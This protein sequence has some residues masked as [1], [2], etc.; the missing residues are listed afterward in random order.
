MKRRLARELAVA[1]LYELEMNEMV[2]VDKASDFVIEM[3]LEE[4]NALRIDEADLDPRDPYLS[5]LIKGVK[6]EEANIDALLTQGLKK[7]NIGR[8]SRVDKQI[9]RIALYELY[10]A[11]ERLSL[12]VAVNEAV[13][14]A[15]HFGD[16]DADKFVNGVLRGIVRAQAGEEPSEVAVETPDEADAGMDVDAETVV[17]ANETDKALF[18]AVNAAAVEEDGETVLDHVLG[19]VIGGVLGAEAVQHEDDD[20]GNGAS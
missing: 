16:K 14:L 4:D 15:K 8:L 2:P 12:G 17:E 1:S 18:G 20:E 10:F 13:E 9:L 6:A 19:E 5:A 3:S 7:W 11:E